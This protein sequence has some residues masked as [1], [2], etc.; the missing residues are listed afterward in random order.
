MEFKAD[1]ASR[2]S[3]STSS[4]TNLR[5]YYGRLEDV[6]ETLKERSLLFHLA[7]A[8]GPWPAT[9]VTALPAGTSLEGEIS[10]QEESVA[11]LW[12]KRYHVR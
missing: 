6:K 11:D 2:Q 3:S 9:A 1:K 7:D 8:S 12:S 5:F 10:Y 4:L